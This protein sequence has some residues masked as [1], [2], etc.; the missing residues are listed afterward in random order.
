MAKLTQYTRQAQPSAGQNIISASAGNAGVGLQQAGADI[1]E[2]AGRFQQAIAR[3]ESRRDAVAETKAEQEY[4]NYLNDE[5]NKIQLEQDI[6]SP[7]V[8]TDYGVN[9]RAKLD[10]ILSLHEGTDDSGARLTARLEQLFG[11][12]SRTLASASNALGKK[13]VADGLQVSFT[14][15]AEDVMLTGDVDGGMT[16]IDLVIES[17][18]GGMTPL[19]ETA[20]R[21]A[22][23]SAV[24]AAGFERAMNDGDFD[25]A[26]SIIDMEGA[27]EDMGLDGHRALRRTLTVERRKAEVED[28]KFATEVAGIEE[29]LGRELTPAELAK[30]AGIA[31]PAGSPKQ[32]LSEWIDEYTTVVGKA[33]TQDQIDKKAGVYITVAEGQDGGAFG[34]GLQGRVL[35]I[36]SN[37]SVGFASGT[38]GEQEER[39]FQAALTEWLQPRSVPNPDTGVMELITPTLPPF[40]AEALDRR[41]IDPAIYTEAAAGGEDADALNFAE[42]EIPDVPFDKTL[43][44][45]SD[46]IT[47]PLSS[48]SERASRAPGLGGLVP[49]PETVQARTRA[50]RQVS[51]LVRILQNNPRFS[52][53]ERKAINDEMNIRPAFFDTPEAYRNRLVGIS[54]ALD[55]RKVQA[56]SILDTPR[57]ATTVDERKWAYRALSAIDGF[58]AIMGVPPMVKTRDEA[59]Q[60]PPGSLFRT[61]DGRILRNEAAPSGEEDE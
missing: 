29:V 6:T 28:N 2:T 51:E 57:G 27:A 26:Q 38:L 22:G 5:V 58:E 56:R 4:M 25:R 23:R 11:S 39:V 15:V 45:A 20:Q 36:F 33:P 30:K 12:S 7:S 32:G 60:L 46:L 50:E 42:G 31:A 14:G 1:T 8:L 61:P 53:T 59:S 40:V 48:L 18:V 55:A 49:S 35:D 37:N 41:G 17:K 16:D 24:I 34:N 44:G 47:G 21:A 52:E 54:D 43:F 19:E 3:K 10:Q 13:L 9:A